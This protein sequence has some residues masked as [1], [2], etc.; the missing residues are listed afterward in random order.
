MHINSLNQV[1]ANCATDVNETSLALSSSIVFRRLS[2]INF[3]GEFFFL[4]F[5]FDDFSQ[6]T[7]WKLFIFF[8]VYRGA[9]GIVK[10]ELWN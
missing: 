3:N 8:D 4:R 5:N 7:K 2:A 9:D 1:A 10:T 6:K